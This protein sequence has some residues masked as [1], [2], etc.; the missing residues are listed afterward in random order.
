[1]CASWHVQ[2]PFLRHFY[3]IKKLFLD[4]FWDSIYTYIPPPPLLRHRYRTK[5][6]TNPLYPMPSTSTRPDNRPLFQQCV[7]IFLTCFQCSLCYY[8]LF[9][10]ASMAIIINYAIHASCTATAFISHMPPLMMIC[11][12]LLICLFCFFCLF[13]YSPSSNLFI[14]L[15]PVTLL[16]T[17]QF[18]AD[19]T[20][21]AGSS[22]VSNGDDCGVL[23][24]LVSCPY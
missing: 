16:L 8:F 20:S 9:Y 17:G 24:L 4:W 5:K 13:L 18:S 10:S 1:M 7:Y 11:N 23:L 15:L 14:L 6:N 3:P 22:K 12:I 2:L 21:Y 19:T